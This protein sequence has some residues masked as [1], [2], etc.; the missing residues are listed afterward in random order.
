MQWYKS[1]NTIRH[2][3]IFSLHICSLHSKI[4]YH[5]DGISHYFTNAYK[6]V[7]YNDILAIQVSLI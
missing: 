6:I 2:A 3:S 4:E 5:K 1:R 7:Y